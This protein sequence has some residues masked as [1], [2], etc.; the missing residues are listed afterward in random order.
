MKRSAVRF[1]L[2]FH[3]MRLSPHSLGSLRHASTLY[4]H[5]APAF[6]AADHTP[7]RPG[8]ESSNKNGRWLTLA[9]LVAYLSSMGCRFQPQASVKPEYTMI[10]YPKTFHL[11]FK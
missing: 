4:V 6:P 8:D 3:S 10:P 7:L 2:Q 5:F 1:A 11:V 9:L